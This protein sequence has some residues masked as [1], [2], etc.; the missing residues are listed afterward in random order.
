MK[1]LVVGGTQY[2]GIHLVRQLL[3]NGH[4]I[5]I[6]TRGKTSDDFGDAISRIIVERTCAD[7]LKHALSG[8]CYDVVYDTQAYSSSEVKHL[9]EAVSCGRYIEVSTVS[10]YY[11][12]FKTSQPESDFDP[13]GHL[14]KWCS[15]SDFG[16]DEVKRQAECAMFQTYSRVPSVAVRFPLIIGEDDYTR[17]LYFYVDHVVNSKPMHIDNLPI[18]MEFIMS[19]E[20]GKFLAW[21][22][23]KDFCGS[24]NAANIGS[25]KLCDVIRYVETKTGNEAI[26][27]PDGEPAPFN[28]FPNYG[29]DL[30]K[31]RNIGYDFSYLEQCLYDLLDKYIESAKS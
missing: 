26:I 15:R 1:I 4:E 21:L 3:A 17:R 11:P 28:G 13:T 16:Y 25:V 24:V 2:V 12:I 23:D 30:S 20:A 9:M 31:A 29:L 5:T 10:V 8:K 27:M 14:L 6:A 18:Q 19:S 7:S 22:A